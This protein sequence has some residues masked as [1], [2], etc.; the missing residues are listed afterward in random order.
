MATQT[1][2]QEESQPDHKSPQLSLTAPTAPKIQDF[3]KLQ[4]SAIFQMLEV[5]QM[6][7]GGIISLSLAL[8][9]I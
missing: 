9:F 6:P 8:F 4:A 1:N 7:Q 2:L 3:V 5:V